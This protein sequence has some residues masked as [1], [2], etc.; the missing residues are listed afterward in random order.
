MG[1]DNG[2]LL[3][4]LLIGGLAFFAI[5]EGF[6]SESSDGTWSFTYDHETLVS[7]HENEDW[8]GKEKKIRKGTYFNLKELLSDYKSFE[9]APKSSL[10]FK[11]DNKKMVIIPGKY[12]SSKLITMF[13]DD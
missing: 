10:T 9:I 13:N 6:L 2:T 12:E 4:L 7:F 5:K 3:L 1:D 11:L 8:S